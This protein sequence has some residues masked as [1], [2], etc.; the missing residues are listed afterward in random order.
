MKKDDLK[1]LRPLVQL[2]PAAAV[3]ALVMATLPRLKHLRHSRRRRMLVPSSVGRESTT[4][5]S[6]WPQNGHFIR[7]HP[8]MIQ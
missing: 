8:F 1:K 2:V 7:L 3:V 4:L 6:S 5:L